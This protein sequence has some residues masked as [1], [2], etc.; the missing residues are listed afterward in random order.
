MVNIFL[1]IL[2]VRKLK[3]KG[4]NNWTILSQQ[5]R[6]GRKP[7]LRSHVGLSDTKCDLQCDHFHPVLIND[8]RP[9]GTYCWWGWVHCFVRARRIDTQKFITRTLFILTN[10]KEVYPKSFHKDCPG[11]QPHARTEMGERTS[12][13]CLPCCQPSSLLS[14][15]TTWWHLWPAWPP[16]QDR[17]SVWAAHVLENIITFF[18]S[19]VGKLYIW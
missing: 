17:L 2:K 4:V 16:H 8:S 7:E 11:A 10:G 15:F 12:V 19:T 9:S 3:P 6:L 1:P 14:V 18:K 5:I 13:Q